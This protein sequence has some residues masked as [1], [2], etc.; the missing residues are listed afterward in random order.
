MTFLIKLNALRLKV[1]PLF[2]FKILLIKFQVIASAENLFIKCK[3]PLKLYN[4]VY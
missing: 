2:S 1:L 3:D 4:I